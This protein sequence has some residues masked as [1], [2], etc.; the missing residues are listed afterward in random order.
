MNAWTMTKKIQRKDCLGRIRTSIVGTQY[1]DGQV[2][3]GEAVHI[4]R[5]PENSHDSN[6]I[7]VENRDFE[8]VGY[9]PARIVFWLAPLIDAGKIRIVGKVPGNIPE[10][11]RQATG[12]IPLELDITLSPRGRHILQGPSEPAN[13]REAL[14]TLISRA[15]ADADTYAHPDIVRELHMLLKP[16]AKRDILPETHLLLHLLLHRQK[17]RIALCHQAF[18]GGHVGGLALADD[19]LHR[20]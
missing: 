17:A 12:E 15:Y 20:P 1:H 18:D 2:H 16:L 5:E 8:Q 9:L 13:A 4:E 7:R 3:P 6:A 10:D 14:H 11:P 19:G